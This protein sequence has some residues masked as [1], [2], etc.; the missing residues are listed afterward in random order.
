MLVID[1]EASG[2]TAEHHSIV[3]LG[4]LD[5]ENPSNRFYAECRVW[6]GAKIAEDALAVNGFTMEEVTD[7]NKMSEEELIR[8]FIGWSKD[9]NNRTFL[10]Q[11][12]SMDRNWAQAAAERAGE[13]WPFAHRT[14]D[15]HSLGC[16][17]RNYFRSLSNL[18]FRGFHNI[19]PKTVGAKRR[20][21]STVLQYSHVWKKFEK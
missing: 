4:A 12:V 11:N 19:S 10:G 3:S 13:D 16:T 15:T 5:L 14:I 1:I 7:P 9:L 2:L 20:P 6:S 21:F 8:N 18:R 17:T